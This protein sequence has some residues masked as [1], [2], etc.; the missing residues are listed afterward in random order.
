MSD[1]RAV[2]AASS[3]S[4]NRHHQILNGLRF[5]TRKSGYP[6][7]SLDSGRKEFR[8]V[9]VLPGDET[10]KVHCHLR[11][12]SLLD[13][14]LPAYET[15]SYTWGDSVGLETIRIDE[16]KTAVPINTAEVLRRF[17]RPNRLR[18]LFVDAVC[19]NQNDR[20]ERSGQVT[21]MGEIYKKCARNLIWLGESDMLQAWSAREAVDDVLA[22]MAR[23]TDDFRNV[24]DTLWRPDG[25]A[26][27]LSTGFTSNINISALVHVYSRPWFERLWVC[28]LWTITRRHLLTSHLKAFSRSSSGQCEYLLSW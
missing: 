15:V 12:V 27:R 16:Y 4:A 11:K 13:D 3:G 2:E 10:H 1:Q 7:S 25:S 21:V 17:R 5:W 28:M 8:V 19:I 22:D 18:T 9:D 6:Y 14:P 23:E 26:K 24:I 20:H